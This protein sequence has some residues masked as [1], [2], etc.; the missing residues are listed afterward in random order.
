MRRILVTL[1]LLLC[2]AAAQ[3]Y[4]AKTDSCLVQVNDGDTLY[5]KTL[6]TVYVYPPMRFKNKKQEKF[7][8]RTVRDVKKTL[9]IAKILTQEMIRTHDIMSKM[10]RREQ[11]KFWKQYEKM[12]YAQYE[13][14]FRG[15]TASQGQMLMK[16]IDRECGHT[17]YD[18]IKFY[19]GGFVASFWQTVAKMVGNDLKEEYDGS[20][21]DKITER[22]I[23]LVEAGQL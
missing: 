9:P 4:A 2:L 16:L 20:D 19:K 22:I 1:S 21:K 23:T 6:R 8:W 18:V 7:Y 3:V 15:M 5:I 13:D 10:N 14:Q 17:S 12:L 11:R